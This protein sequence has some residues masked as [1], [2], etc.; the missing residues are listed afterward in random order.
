MKH[1]VI[2]LEDQNFNEEQLKYVEGLWDYLEELEE[3]TALDK[4]L[5][6]EKQNTALLEAL[7]E[8]FAAYKD[9]SEEKDLSKLAEPMLRLTKAVMKAKATIALAEDGDDRKEQDNKMDDY[10]HS[11]DSDDLAD[12]NEWQL[13]EN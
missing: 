12:L 2:R 6:L 10:W 8:L 9:L 13:G 4:V 1:T 3:N 5:K 11:T 7:K